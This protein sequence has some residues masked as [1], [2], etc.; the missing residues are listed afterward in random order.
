MS[1]F[2]WNRSSGVLCP[3]CHELEL[4]ARFSCFAARFRCTGCGCSYDLAELFK[5]LDASDFATLAT[6]VEDRHSD[7]V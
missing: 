5:R 1:R 3:H 2:G 7:R 4:T 6:L